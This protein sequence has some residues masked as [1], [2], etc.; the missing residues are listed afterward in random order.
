M[1]ITQTY[2]RALRDI[3]E[4]I[5]ALKQNLADLENERNELIKLVESN[6]TC[7]ENTMDKLTA[8]YLLIKRMVGKN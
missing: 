2:I 3:T 4:E 5:E 1:N 7:E 8:D 6:R